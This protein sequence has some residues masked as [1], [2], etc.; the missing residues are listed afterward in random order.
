MD[1]KLMALLSS[2]LILTSICGFAYSHWSET[3][4]IRGSV[5]TGRWKACVRIQKTLE[6]AFTDPETGADLT[7][8]T[9]LIAIANTTFPTKFKLTIWV[10][11]C[12]STKLANIVVTDV[13]ESQIAPTSWTPS[14]GTVSWVD[15]KPPGEPGEFVF[16]YLTWTIGTL[17]PRE[18]AYLEI[19]IETL[20]N[21]KGKY[22]PTSGDE[23]DTQDLPINRGA[24]VMADSPLE[25]LSATT[26]AITILIGDDD[27]PENGIGKIL[28]P[29][30]YSTP[31]AEDGFT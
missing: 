23:G 16:D 29:L 19:W 14:K 8:P 26:E 21:P 12:E 11:N 4:H 30:P 2:I 20:R 5:T 27:T 24:A 25:S 3:L 10:K 28:T 31:W 9:N 6:G 17:A 1:R 18:S 13:I 7:T 15:E 22:E